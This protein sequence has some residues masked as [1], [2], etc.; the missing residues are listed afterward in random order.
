[1]DQDI[2]RPVAERRDW[3]VVAKLF[4]A[5]LWR[6]LPTYRGRYACEAVDDLRRE[7]DL[8]LDRAYGGLADALRRSEAEL[9]ELRQN[10]AHVTASLADSDQRLAAEQAK[11]RQQAASAK[12]ALNKALRRQDELELD[13]RKLP[14]THVDAASEAE[15]VRRR[16]QDDSI[17]IRAE[18]VSYT[19]LTLPTILRV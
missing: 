12:R 3:M 8:F 11:S 18:A 19:H 15:E 17:Q 4:R 16:A 6:E 14:D 2:E 7:A 13:L 9:S 5:S 10:L 1:M